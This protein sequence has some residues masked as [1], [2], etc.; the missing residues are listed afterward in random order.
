MHYRNYRI[1]AAV[2]CIKRHRQTYTKS[3]FK[4]TINMCTYLLHKMFTPVLYHFVDVHNVHHNVPKVPHQNAH[5]A[6]VVGYKPNPIDCSLHKYTYKICKSKI[7]YS[8]H[9]DI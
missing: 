6:D 8:K 1:D 5:V 3:M 7:N 4:H 9:N 2:H